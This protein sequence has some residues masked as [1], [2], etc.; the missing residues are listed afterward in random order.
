MAY[1]GLISIGLCADTHYW[2]H[3]RNYVTSDG[4]LQLQG[5]TQDL[6]AT[7]FHELR[8]AQLDMLLHLGDLTCGGGTY[9]M[10]PDE[11]V[12]TVVDLYR[13][14]QSLDM[15]VHVL[16]GNHDSLPGAGGWDA[17]HDAW[18]LEPGLG[19]TVDLPLARLIL[20]NT[21][22]HSS[23]QI[24]QAEDFDP[25][26]GWV[27]DVEL[28]R[29]EESLSSAGDKPVIIFTHQLLAPW[30]N[31]VAW[32]DYFAIRNAA[33]VRSVLSRYS[34]VAAVF[35]AHAHRF[36]V[37]RLP[38]GRHECTFVILP[39]LIE[40]PLAWVQLDFAPNLL[41]MRL[42]QL[43]LPTLQEASRS[44]GSGQ[45]WRAGRREWWDLTIP[46]RPATIQ[47]GFPSHSGVA[48]STSVYLDSVPSDAGH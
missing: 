13:T 7:L 41:R 10:G 18:G 1:G 31:H 46:L 12:T 32:H 17:F 43:P 23:A 48:P 39:S 4:S 26:Y 16:P 28:N 15:P 36:D 11:F 34:N 21:H 27:S 33:A 24:A 45:E 14:Y 2:P 40:Y 30:S 19:M 6:L 44:S 35:Q 5:A 25:V 47:P 8:S 29:L 20:L 22:G 42:R 37:R 38:L 3:G 9:D